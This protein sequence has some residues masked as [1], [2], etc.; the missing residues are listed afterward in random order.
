MSTV[1]RYTVDT[2]RGHGIIILS[3]N[4]G[5]GR[6]NRHSGVFA[7]ICELSQ[8]SG[9]PLDYP[10]IGGAG[11]SVRNIAPLDTGVVQLWVQVDWGS[12]LNIRIQLL[13][14]ND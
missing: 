5:V 2:I 13:V 12:D 1:T 3:V 11:M 8:P 9:E 6:L 4:V 14:S 7:T 10:F